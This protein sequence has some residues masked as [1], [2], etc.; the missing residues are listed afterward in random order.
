M[1][2]VSSRGG[3]A[4][5]R[6]PIAFGPGKV[7][8]RKMMKTLRTLAVFTI[9][10]LAMCASLEAQYCTTLPCQC[11]D[12]GVWTTKTFQYQTITGPIF[13]PLLLTDGRV[14]VQF[15]GTP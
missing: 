1:R 12:Q 7:W 3:G 14:M 10:L 11:G 5:E 9:A 2:H 6:P 15:F 4:L 8:R 13:T